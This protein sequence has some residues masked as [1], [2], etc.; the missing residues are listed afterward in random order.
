MEQLNGCCYQV[1]PGFETM[2]VAE[3]QRR[4]A[5]ADRAP[6]QELAP[7]MWFIEGP[8]L[9]VAFVAN[10]W[11]DPHTADIPSIGQAAQLLRQHGPYWAASGDQLHRRQQLIAEKLLAYRLKNL[12]LP[13]NKPLKSLGAFTLLDKHRMLFAAQTQRPFANG[14][15]PLAYDH[16]G[17]P[18][19]AYSKIIEAFLLLGHTPQV[20]ER[21]M[22]LGGCPGAW[23]YTMANL[24]A[25]VVGVDK[26]PFDPAVI[27]MPGVTT[28]QQSAFALEPHDWQIDW[29]CSDIICYP[30]RLLRLID[31]WQQAGYT[32]RFIITVKLQGETDFAA[33]EQFQALPNSQLL[34]LSHNKHEV[35]WMQVPGMQGQQ[36]QPWPW[37][38]KT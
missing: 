18:S 3:L 15:A 10:V 8:A 16:Q 23:T 34:H 37:A 26:A 6:P 17:P 22:D 27:A 9:A 12:S 2:S 21:A 24:G 25:E 20:G 30:D 38:I 13:L 33:L 14:H 7:G 11:F 31:N 28:L 36:A 35:T 5:A 29:L 32:K 1:C 4:A 19:R